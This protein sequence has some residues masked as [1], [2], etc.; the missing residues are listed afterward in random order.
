MPGNVSKSSGDEFGMLLGHCC[1]PVILDGQV[2]L[3]A[4]LMLAETAKRSS[5]P[6][7]GLFTQ[8]ALVRMKPRSFFIHR[9]GVLVLILLRF[10]RSG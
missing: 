7:T 1:T 2:G 5:G 8:F 3:L 10:R 9:L 6:E 4:A